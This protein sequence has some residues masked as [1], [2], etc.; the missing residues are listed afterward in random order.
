MSANI[1]C[2]ILF[3]DYIDIFQCTEFKKLVLKFKFSYLSQIFK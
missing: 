1:M 2:S 3:R